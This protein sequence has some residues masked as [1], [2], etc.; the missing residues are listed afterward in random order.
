MVTPAVRR[1]RP[2]PDLGLLIAASTG[3]VFGVVAYLAGAR[4]LATA[5]WT[6]ATLAAVGPATVW[7]AGAARRRRLGADVVAL[8]AL[9]GTLAVGEPLAGALIAVMLGTGRSLESW[10]SGRARRTLTALVERAPRVAHRHGATLED[11]GVDEVVPGDRLFVRPGEVVPVDGLLDGGLALLDESSLTGES[12]PVERTV[13]DRVRSGVVNA[14][15]GF[16]LLV[17]A[18]AADSTY[19]GVVAMVSEATA[20]RTPSVRLAD[21]FAGAFLVISLLAAG[22]AWWWSG[23]A[24]RAVAVLVVATPCPLILAVPVAVV[25]GVSSAARRGVIVKSGAALERLATCRTLLFDKTGTIT[26]GHPSVVEVVPLGSLPTDEVLRLAASLDQLSPHVLAASIVGAAREAS[27]PLT[28]PV[29]VVE[30]AGRGVR[31]TVE[32]HTVALGKASWVVEGPAGWT[33][34][35]RRRAD[36][37]GAITVFVSVDGAP[38]GGILLEDPIRVDAGQ[39]LRALRRAGISR[40]VMVTG[41]RPDVAEGI[42][43]VIGAD[44][45]LADRAPEDKVDDVRAEQ[46][47]AA[48]VM[49]G[50]GINDAPAL[51]AADV[52]VAIGARGTTATSEAADMVLTADRLDRLADVLR[53]ARR[54]RRIAL[55]SAIAGI[56]LSMMA[57]AVAATGA[58]A[59]TWG[60]LLQELIDVV[61]ILNALRVLR[62]DPLIR[63]LAPEEEA[64]AERFRA[65]HLT[66]RPQVERLRE[67]ADH[68]GELDPPKT[69]ATLAEVDRFLVEELG[70]HEQAEDALLYPII[71]RALGGGEATG[72]MSRGHGEIA[73]LSRR[74]HRLVEQLDPDAGPDG[75]DLRELRRLLYGLHAVLR[76]HFAQEDESYLTLAG[77]AHRSGAAAVR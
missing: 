55:Q 28:M 57:M 44:A 32:R 7:V 37:D 29:D 15:G 41:D 13:G 74:F 47:R 67:V 75:D 19:A 16:G 59:P 36:V 64:V 77:E 63:V 20:T 52:G 56:S 27:M 72:T 54:T 71:D 38:A 53:V 22:A 4:D 14:G 30:V 31:G 69:L 66:L 21:R 61:V 68:L 1:R 73:R 23:D 48:V 39:T 33:R 49:V 43:A 25:A 10:A 9:I 65:Q 50:D 18:A 6:F 62:P 24:V 11:I 5:A 12:V 8:L 60:A 42:G 58:L 17:T 46:N 34:P 40:T 45:V 70:P 3:L 35:A 51:A 76:L 26:A 2:G